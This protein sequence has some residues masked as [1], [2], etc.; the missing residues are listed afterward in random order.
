MQ[1]RFDF[2]NGLIMSLLSSSIG[3]I[4]LYMIFTTTNGYPG[5]SLQQIFLFQ[6]VL[7]FWNGIKDMLFGD[8]RDN[9]N[10]MIRKGD[11]D[12][13]L[14]KPYPPIGLIL[15]GGANY[16]SIG[17]IFAGLLIMILSI[18]KLGIDISFKGLF[19][20]VLFTLSAVILYMTCLVI[21]C[22]VTIMIVYMG[23]IAEIMNKLLS[24]GEYPMEIYSAGAKWLFCYVFPLSIMIYLPTQ[25][26]LGRLDLKSFI[27]IPACLIL[28]IVS[29][30]LWNRCLKKYTST[31][32]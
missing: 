2:I 9:I 8:V 11:F 19:Y 32:G 31:G 4:T 7:L 23:R 6:G 1:Y 29:I 27:S 5:W 28:F 18:I 16:M 3:V 15:T 20:F 30:L 17:T 24:F 25:S 13:L 21:Y 26:L 10:S 22:V 12:R 14:L